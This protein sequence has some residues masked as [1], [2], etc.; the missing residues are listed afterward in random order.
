MGINKRIK[1]N[2]FTCI[3]DKIYEVR[4]DAVDSR[5][6]SDFLCLINTILQNRLFQKYLKTI[7]IHIYTTKR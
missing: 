5:K 4:V 3:L 7:D 6:K 2:A 1:T